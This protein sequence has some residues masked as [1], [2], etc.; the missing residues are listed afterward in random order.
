[1]DE[2][3]AAA[4]GGFSVVLMENEHVKQLFG[5]LEENGKDT[6]GLAA[7]INHV[8]GM[9][10]FV[11]RAEDRIADMKAQL[12]SMKE[13]QD[14][15]IKAK[16]QKTIK[17]L[18]TKVAE[19]KAQIAELKDNIIEGCKNAVASF[20]EHGAAALNKLASFFHIKSGLQ[21][22]KNDTVKSVDM[23]DRSIARVE[24]FSQ[25][26]HK[27]GS[28]LKNMARVLV[29]K[30]PVDAVKE[31]GR[32][33]K[34]LSAP[35]K[36]EKACWLGIRKQADKMIAALDKL[37]QGVEAKRSEKAADQPKKPTLME[38]L[39]AKKKEIKER[40]REEP[41]KERVKAKGAEI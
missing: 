39:D 37:E 8:S 26:Y 30:P 32:L 20:K 27:A 34:A 41:K 24:T 25:E 33:A 16:L 4:S 29:G 19:V 36:A 3:T 6:S 18:E 5:I 28:A 17:A 2:N 12:E 15:P 31:S 22:I 40:E 1:M 13:V 10:D 7:L 11:K 9:E 21:A 35:A 23:C 14:H 38:R